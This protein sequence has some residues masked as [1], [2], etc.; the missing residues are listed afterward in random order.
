VTISRV[1]LYISGVVQGVSYRYWTQHT[2][3]SLGLS[4]WVRN[5]DDGRVEA[6]AE[7][8]A[9]KVDRFVELCHKGPRL[10]MVEKVEISKEPVKYES[11][12]EILF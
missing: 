5:L 6:V 9:E 11:G 7:G 1:H 4:G 12:F 8:P 2:A 3:G 10:A